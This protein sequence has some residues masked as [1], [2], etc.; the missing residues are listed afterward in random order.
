MS[1]K[2]TVLF[3]YRKALGR[4]RRQTTS[5]TTNSTELGPWLDD[6]ANKKKI[7]NM[8]LFYV[9]KPNAEDVVKFGIAGTRGEAG[10]WGRLHQ[11]INEYGYTTDLNRCTGIQLLYL[12]GNKYNSNVEITNSD[13]F[14]KER[15]CK[16]YVAKQL[17]E[18]DAIIAAQ[19]KEIE[20]LTKQLG[21]VKVKA[22]P[23]IVGLYG[24]KEGTI[25]REVYEG[26]GK[27]V[28]KSYF[29]KNPGGGKK[30]LK[31]SDAA[32]WV[33]MDEETVKERVAAHDAK[34]AALKNSSPAK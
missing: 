15:A 8:R 17:A 9:L 33:A 27:G 7:Y 32:N 22:E 12:A 21:N 34:M 5:S 20:E 11:Y 24:N 2:F 30:Y 26:T 10:G 14:K 19:A 28:E 29:T 31:D 18:K 13:V 6:F 23:K 1:D 3:D 16:Q 4:T 25:V